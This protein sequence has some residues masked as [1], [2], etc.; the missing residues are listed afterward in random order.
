MV[1][2]TYDW[3]L[4]LIMMSLSPFM[5]ICGLF[6]AKLLATAATKE[7]KQYAVAGGIAEEVLTSIRTVIA[8][9]G[10]DYECKRYLKLL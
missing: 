5:M 10:Q 4:T 2:F 1:A 6:L 8:F 7:A 3:L 9:N